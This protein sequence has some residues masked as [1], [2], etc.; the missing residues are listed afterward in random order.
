MHIPD[1]AERP[2]LSVDETAELLAIGRSTAYGG[3]HSGQI[4]SIRVGTRIRVP[5]AA[6][7]RLLQLE[8]EVEVP[9]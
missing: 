1:P 9:A 6:V 8:V 3:I 5:T 7:L 2:T 4:P